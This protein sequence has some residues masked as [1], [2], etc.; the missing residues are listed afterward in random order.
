MKTIFIGIALFLLTGGTFLH[1]Q[2]YYPA[3]TISGDLKANATSVIREEVNVFS[4]KSTSEGTFH[5][6]QIVTVLN[7]KSDANK[8]Y[9][10]YDKESKVT[11]IKATLYDALGQKIRK[12]KG[13]EIRD[14]S[15]IEDFSIYQDDRYKYLEVNHHSYPFTIEFE[16]EIDLKG[17]PFITYKDWFIQEFEQSVE[18]SSFM[19][20][21]PADQTFH[22]KALNFA[23]EPKESEEKGRKFYQWEVSN[24]VGFE[25]EPYSPRTFDILP[26]L[27]LSP[28]KFKIGSYEGSMDSWVNFGKFMNQLLEGRDELP[29][30]MKAE[31][32]KIVADANSEREKINRLYAYVQQNMRYVSVQ[33]GVGGWQPFDAEYVATKK[34]GDCKALSNFMGALLKEAGIVSYPVLIYA[35]DLDYEVEEDFTTTRFNHMVLHV[36][37]EDY[38]LDCTMNDYPPNYLGDHNANRNVMLVTPSGGRLVKTPKLS[39]EDNQDN[40]KALIT[41]A[42]DGSAKIAVEIF[43]SGASQETYR[44]V[45]KQLSKEEKEKWLA[46]ASDLPS[47]SIVS[48][49]IESSMEKPEARFSYSV[50]VVRYAAKAGK[51]LFVPFNLINNWTHVPPSVENRKHNIFREGAF[52]DRDEIILDIPEG[53]TLESIPTEKKRVECEAGYYDLTIEKKENQ[54]ICRRELRLEA[55]EF[56]ATMYDSFRD[57][58]KEIAKLDGMKLV[59]VEKKT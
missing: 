17:M 16:Y 58:F 48:F 53:Y 31:V 52:W 50:D 20:D 22:Y 54:L 5:F 59:L 15:A 40:H 24:L 39:A 18:H 55:G 47:F 19:V 14:F 36:P 10:A 7:K 38:W 4:I 34:Y 12:I 26:A 57:F 28:D 9:V 23:G 42:A 37:S 56:P 3:L 29:E 33:L 11:D 35:G 25:R 30:V 51:R 21:L 27:F 6:R 13:D 2:L 32:T 49:D 1:A 43:A 45:E 41:L 46:K 44:A 8:F